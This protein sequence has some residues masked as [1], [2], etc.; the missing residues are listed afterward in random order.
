MAF[1][2]QLTCTAVPVLLILDIDETLI[3]AH[4]ASSGRARPARPPDFFVLGRPAYERP[5]VRPFIRKMATHFTL[6]VWS[7]ADPPHVEGVLDAVWPQG[8]ERAFTWTSARCT[9]RY[10]EKLQQPYWVK[11]LKKVKNAGY[12]LE[13]MLV[14]DDDPK[15]HEDNYGNLVR[16]RPYYGDA[17]RELEL[18]ARYLPTL[19]GVPNVR[20]VEKRGWRSAVLP[21]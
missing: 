16:V 15:A 20:R 17:D 10:D 11:K 19:R 18:L 14:V 5:Y 12:P 9:R 4:D 21:P 6:A 7:K 13:Q 3:Y 8:V 2:T 1:A